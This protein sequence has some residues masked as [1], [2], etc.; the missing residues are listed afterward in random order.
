MGDILHT[1]RCCLPCRA[2]RRRAV[3][4]L[5]GVIEFRWLFREER[6]VAL[7]G[8]AGGKRQG[9]TPFHFAGTRS[10]DITDHCHDCSMEDSLVE[11]HLAAPRSR[12]SV[13]SILPI[14]VVH[15]APMSSDD[16]ADSVAEQGVYKMNDNGSWDNDK[17]SPDSEEEEFVRSGTGIL[18]RAK[19]AGNKG[20]KPLLAADSLRFR[21]WIRENSPGIAISSDEAPTLA[22]H[23]RDFWIPFA[24]LASD[25]ALQVYLGLVVSYV[26]DCLK[27]ALM[28]DRHT[29]HVTAVYEDKGEGLLKRFEYSGPVDGLQAC[30]KEIDLRTV[31]KE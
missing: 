8:S 29:I 1:A 17:Y 11:S 28:H 13:T 19:P 24:V 21:K 27:G 3:E 5:C 2:A 15:E 6:R 14:R 9:V 12:L 18:F 22:L 7:A 31:L 10:A 4:G 26:Y 23:S 16:M 25:V 20:G 30:A